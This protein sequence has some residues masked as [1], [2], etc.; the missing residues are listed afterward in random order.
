MKKHLI[1]M[2]IA[3]T[4]FALVLIGTT[5]S[6]ALIEAHQTTMSNMDGYTIEFKEQKANETDNLTHQK[7]V[8]VDNTKNSW[9]LSSYD[10][11][12][13]SLC[14]ECTVFSSRESDIFEYIYH[15]TWFE[16]PS[17]D[18]LLFLK[19]FETTLYEYLKEG[20][21]TYVNQSLDLSYTTT[22]NDITHDYIDLFDI[23][24]DPLFYSIPI[25]LSAT[26]NQLYKRFTTFSIDLTP[27]LEA[28]NQY[29]F[30]VDH[31]SEWVI[32]ITYKYINQ[33]FEFEVPQAVQD[34]YVNQV[35]FINTFYD[36]PLYGHDII[37]GAF[38]YTNDADVFSI[39][40]ES[41]DIYSIDCLDPNRDVPLYIDLYD[42]SYELIY[43]IHLDIGA[44]CSSYYSLPNGQYTLRIHSNEASV[45]YN[46]K[47]IFKTH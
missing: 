18:S 36:T 6:D 7:F 5:S 22:L 40:I 43:T 39:I 25:T 16:L 15:G 11:S 24:I 47:L 20:Q 10:D 26:Y 46:Y 32:D 23:D 31:D 29:H 13:G 2:V 12:D 17:D 21:S 42:E 14:I 33:T 8:Y 37:K 38:N 3:V 27:I 19:T 34:D 9:M 41:T 28:M 30:I 44:S 35:N 4:L 45:G 1:Y